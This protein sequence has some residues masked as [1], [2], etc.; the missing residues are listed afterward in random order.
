MIGDPSRRRGI[1]IDG[2]PILRSEPD[3]A[4]CYSRNVI[5]G[6]AAFITVAKDISGFHT[7]ELEKFVTEIAQVGAQ[8]RSG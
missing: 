3:I 8:S 2:L 1:A 6:E 5:G 7:D 4:T